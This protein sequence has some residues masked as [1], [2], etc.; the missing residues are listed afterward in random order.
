MM[1]YRTVIQFMQL[2]I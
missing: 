2:V 1:Y